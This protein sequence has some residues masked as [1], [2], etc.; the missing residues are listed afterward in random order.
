[1]EIQNTSF[2]CVYVT[3][4]PLSASC[5]KLRSAMQKLR[6]WEVNEKH[7][8]IVVNCFSLKNQLLIIQGGA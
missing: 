4:N 1:M 8:L 2:A 3:M 7:L 6:I 5:R